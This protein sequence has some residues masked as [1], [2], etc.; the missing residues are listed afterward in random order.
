MRQLEE[1]GKIQGTLLLSLAFMVQI[2]KLTIHCSKFS[3]IKRTGIQMRDT[4]HANNCTFWLKILVK[5]VN[6]EAI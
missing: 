4:N 2:L 5:D 3:R 1:E 6:V